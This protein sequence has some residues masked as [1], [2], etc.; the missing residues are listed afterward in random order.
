V[1]LRV[2][3]DSLESSVRV[4]VCAYCEWR[5]GWSEIR[6]REEKKKEKGKEKKL[7]KK[8]KGK[9]ERFARRISQRRPRPVAHT[10][11]SGVARRSSVRDARN[12][13]KKET[14][15]IDFGCRGGDPMG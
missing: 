2:A 10:R 1:S 4:Q 6:E 9:R 12:R 8:N 11:W 15:V 5:E 3:L 14:T 7:K 13:K